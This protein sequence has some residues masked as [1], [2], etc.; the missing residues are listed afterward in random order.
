MSIG[1]K[2]SSPQSLKYLFS[3]PFLK[4]FA[5]THS[6]VI[7]LFLNWHIWNHK[8]LCSLWFL[9]NARDIPSLVYISIVL[10]ICKSI[11]LYDHST[12]W[13]FIF[14][15]WTFELFVVFGYYQQSYE[16][17]STALCRHVFYFTW[18]WF[19]KDIC[20]KWLYHFSFSQCI[21]VLVDPNHYQ[22]LIWSIF[23]I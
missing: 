9:Y 18:V 8:H 6:R 12:I 4:M 10:F 23:F 2:N 19:K 7:L 14:C 3:S 1:T 13:L 17:S 5:S 15:W 20:Q 21:R 11:L 16:H 22:Y